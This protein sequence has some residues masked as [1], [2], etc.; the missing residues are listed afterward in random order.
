ML[1]RKKGTRLDGT[2][3]S[4]PEND[5][6]SKPWIWLN[7]WDFDIAIQAQLGHDISTLKNNLPKSITSQKHVPHDTH[8]IRQMVRSVQSLLNKGTLSGLQYSAEN[9]AESAHFGPRLSLI[10]FAANPPSPCE[11]S[12]DQSFW[13]S[14]RLVR[15]KFCDFF[16]LQSPRGIKRGFVKRQRP[17]GSYRK[18]FG[19]FHCE[20]RL[21]LTCGFARK[22]F[23]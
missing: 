18:R 13:H 14:P 22:V 8:Q 10:H 20:L 17:K 23:W 2:E 21:L 12:L 9:I 19:I 4:T 7:F 15:K 16:S 1:L 3:N 6:F 5:Y 11:H